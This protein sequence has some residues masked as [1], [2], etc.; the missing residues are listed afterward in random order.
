MVRYL[1][2]TI[3]AIKERLHTVVQACDCETSELMQQC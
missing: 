2:M 1:L 3:L